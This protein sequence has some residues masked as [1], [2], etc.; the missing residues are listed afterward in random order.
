MECLTHSSASSFFF[1]FL[2]LVSHFWNFHDFF[3]SHA[4]KRRN[5]YISISYLEDGNNHGSLRIACGRTIEVV[6][7]FGF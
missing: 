3:A 7:L 6:M 1:K 2:F 5:D 4:V